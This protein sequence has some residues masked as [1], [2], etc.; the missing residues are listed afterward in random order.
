MPNGTAH[1]RLGPLTALE[2][3]HLESGKRPYIE[4]I[5][6]TDNVVAAMPQTVKKYIHTNPARP[7]LIRP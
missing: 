1:L 5:S 3:Y 4:A 6:A 7:P 2:L